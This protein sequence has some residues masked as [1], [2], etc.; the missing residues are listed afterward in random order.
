MGTAP[1]TKIEHVMWAI[2]KSSIFVFVFVLF[3]WKIIWVSWSKFPEKLQ[4]GI[5]ILVGQA[6]LGIIYQIMENI[7]FLINNS[8]TVWP[9]CT[10]MLMPVVFLRWFAAGYLYTCTLFF[11]LISLLFCFVLFKCWDS[12][13]NMFTFDEGAVLP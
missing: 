8:S 6:V 9:T 13:Q 12:T 7:F 1:Q 3:C 11:Y 4:N 10:K 5:S 2:L